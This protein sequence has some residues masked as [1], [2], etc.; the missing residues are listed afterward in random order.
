MRKLLTGL[1]LGTAL[2]TTT[3]LANANS[4]G[5]FTT[6]I[7][8]IPTTAIRIDVLLSEDLAY[9]A[10]NL[11][12]NISSR[13]SSRGL[14]AGFANNG[15]IGEKDLN[16]LLVKLEKF[17]THDLEKRGISVDDNAQSVLKLT[18]VDARPN[19][20]TFNQL[21]KQPSLDFQS[22]G[23]GGAEIEGELFSADGTSQGKVNYTYYETFFNGFQRTAAV[24]SDTRRTMQRF[25]SRLAKD[26]AKRRA[27]TGT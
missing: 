10:N 4:R 12:K 8:N 21:S 25:S 20:P 5:G 3:N 7:E 23:F 27:Q 14:R 24:W 1:V 15:L 26:F 19:R 13:T 22:F 18:L 9:R 17:T 11:P 16:N 2:F 6:T